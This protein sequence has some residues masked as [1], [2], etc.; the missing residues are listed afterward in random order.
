MSLSGA[1]Y[2]VGDKT[3]GF[4]VAN[5]SRLDMT[6]LAVWMILMILICD[7]KCR[8]SSKISKHRFPTAASLWYYLV[9]FAEWPDRHWTIHHEPTHNLCRRNF[10][11]DSSESRFSLRP[12][13]LAGCEADDDY[14]LMG[15]LSEKPKTQ[16]GIDLKTVRVYANISICKICLT[17][18]WQVVRPEWTP[19]SEQMFHHL[20]VV[21]TARGNEVILPNLWLKCSHGPRPKEL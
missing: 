2:S 16:L 3:H 20:L 7:P 15:R 19:D 8:F 6:D 18:L 14:H 21:K 11:S 12:C 13:S 5:L 1:A 17:W 10:S 4:S 9:W